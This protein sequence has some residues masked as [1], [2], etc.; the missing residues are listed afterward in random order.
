MDDPWAHMVLT[1]PEEGPLG[2]EAAARGRARRLN[3]CKCA[4]LPGRL[5]SSSQ[6]FLEVG[7]SFSCSGRATWG[8]LQTASSRGMQ[9]ESHSGR[10]CQDCAPLGPS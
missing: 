3:T 7:C 2:R 4:A 8:R 1:L 5:G 6:G 10:W 9:A